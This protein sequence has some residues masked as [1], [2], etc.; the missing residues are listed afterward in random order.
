MG[1]LWEIGGFRVV[2]S[3]EETNVLLPPESCH[4][5]GVVDYFFWIQAKLWTG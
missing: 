5:K 3:P 2:G 1:D 4:K